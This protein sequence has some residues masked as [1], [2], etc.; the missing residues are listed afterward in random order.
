MNTSNANVGADSYTDL[1][2]LNSITQLGK[3]DKGQ[4]LGKIAEQFE[5]MMVRMMMKSM[6]SANSVFAEGNFLSSKE[7]DMY[8]DM[9]DDQIALS[10]S[11]GRGMG[12]AEVMVRQLNQRFGSEEK[13]IAAG[14]LQEY[15][16]KRNNY[17]GFIPGLESAKAAASDTNEQLAAKPV[18]MEFDG[19]RESFISQ[20]YGMAK[21]AA[22]KL[23]IAPEAL[24]A[25]AGLETGWGKKITS[26]GEKSS[27]NLFNI[28]A[29]KRW[30]GDSVTVQTLEVRQGI[31]TKEYAAFRSYESP[32]QSFD[33]Y[34]EFISNSPRYEKARQANDSESYIRALE[35]AGYAT[36]PQY[37]EKIIRI[38]NSPEMKNAVQHA[39]TSQPIAMAS[40]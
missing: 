2:N 23:G 28:K 5:S 13:A 20:V 6:R 17:S 29:D 31:P 19:S 34:V 37:S 15:L 4:A 25:Q 32:K 1:A 30:Q 10:L 35:E 8:Q 24:I 16:N 14:S 12:I 11:Q 18:A 7:G 3:T 40:H 39:V 27:F 26:I 21:Q 22:E 38:L 36:D 33:D 9:F